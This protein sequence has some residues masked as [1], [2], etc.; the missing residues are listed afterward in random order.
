MANKRSTV[1][2]TTTGVSAIIPTN[3]RAVT[4][5]ELQT[6]LSGG[7]GATWKVQYTTDDI[8][9]S[10]FVAANATYFDDATITGS[11]ASISA[12]SSV[13][14]TGIR[15]NCTAH[16]SGTVTLNVLEGAAS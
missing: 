10:D 11:T 3:Y 4:S 8:Q 15:L 9:A 16:T 14:A 1:A 5:R 6:I 13:V 12:L 2:L 7:G